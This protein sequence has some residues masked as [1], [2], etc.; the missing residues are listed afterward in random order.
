MLPDLP[1]QRLLDLYRRMLLIRRFEEELFH[2]TKAGYAFGHFHV[3]IGQETI[4]VLA[5]GQLAPDD[6]VATT[7][8]N[9]GHLLARG[10]DPGRLLAEIMGK[11]TG[12]CKGKGGTLHAT[13]KDLGFLSTSA[14][15]GGVLPLATG[16]GFAA[17]QLGTDRVSVCCF[18]DG[19][20]EEGAYFE[21][22]NI[23]ALWAL[24]V[25]Y[26][27]EN[28]S[29]GAPGTK[30]GEYASSTI[31]AARLTD[32]ATAFQVPATMVDGTDA[33]AVHRAMGEAIGRARRG[34]PSFIEVQ[35]KR[36]PGSRPLWPELLTGVTDLA[37]AWDASRIPPDHADWY[38]THDC[39]LGFT[40][41]LLAAGVATREQVVELD[42]EV[43]AEL[44]RASRFARESP[45]PAPEDAHAD[46]FA[47]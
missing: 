40:R 3:Y 36:W 23:A 7:F 6:Y 45:D 47:S 15:V 19:A 30:A 43:R 24:P 20:M 8:R 31:A 14:S 18:G 44:A 4:G 42:A 29:L 13:V 26:L 41:E 38:T 21:A 11:A 10:A 32:L 35:V 5:L 34:G 37:M 27:C 12:Y 22:I 2:L 1:P 46:V 33:G 9:H 17:K 16:A 39:V 25:I 28:N